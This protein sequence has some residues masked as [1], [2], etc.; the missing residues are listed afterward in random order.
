MFVLD[1]IGKVDHRT[2]HLYAICECGRDVRI[3]PEAVIERYGMD[4]PLSQLKNVVRCS[5]CGNRPYKVQI[6]ANANVGV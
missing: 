3:L 1:T 5:V 2:T 4:F 6:V